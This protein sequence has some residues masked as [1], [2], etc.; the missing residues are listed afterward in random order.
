MPQ[1]RVIRN[2]LKTLLWWWT[3]GLALLGAFYF[4]NLESVPGTNRK[5]FLAI[6]RIVEAFIANHTY[7]QLIDEYGR[8]MLPRT[9]PIKTWVDDIAKRIIAVS[10]LDHLDWEVHIVNSAIR[11]AFVI[12]TGKIFVFTGLLKVA[13]TTDKI[14]AV[15]G[16]E[17]VSLNVDRSC[18]CSSWC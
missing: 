8:Y 11:N 4:S 13:N 6:P 17:V 18:N 16:H 1:L 12:P 7:L 14:A 3:I 2:K 5:R 9:H 15:L 10:G